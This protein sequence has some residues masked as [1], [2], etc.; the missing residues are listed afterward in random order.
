ME[1]WHGP[2][3]SMDDFDYSVHIAERDWSAFFQECEGCDVL[4]GTLASLDDSGMS[5]NDSGMELE[6][7]QPQPSSNGQLNLQGSSLN[8]SG[9][10]VSENGGEE[11]LSSPKV[12][13][14]EESSA[15]LNCSHGGSV[16]MPMSPC[17]PECQNCIDHQ[18]IL[19]K[20]TESNDTSSS[21]AKGNVCHETDED[22]S[23]MM[24]PKQGDGRSSNEQTGIPLYPQ[25]VFLS[26]E[27]SPTDSLTHKEMISESPEN[28]T[29]CTEL[30]RKEKERWFVTVD[31]GVPRSRARGSTPVKKK[32]K[33]ICRLSCELA[34][35]CNDTGPAIQNKPEL[36][37]AAGQNTDHTSESSLSSH[38]PPTCTPKSCSFFIKLLSE[39]PATKK[40]PKFIGIL[41]SE[42]CKNENMLQKLAKNCI[43]NKKSNAIHHELS[44]TQESID[45]SL[46]NITKTELKE[47]N[48][49][50]YSSM[51]THGKTLAH[52]TC[53][54]KVIPVQKIQQAMKLSHSTGNTELK[55]LDLDSNNEYEKYEHKKTNTAMSFKECEGKHLAKKDV[56]GILSAGCRLVPQRDESTSVLLSEDLRAGCTTTHFNSV[57]NPNGNTLSPVTVNKNRYVD[58]GEAHL[59]SALP[60]V[61]G[62]QHTIRESYSDDVA[63]DIHNLQNRNEVSDEVDYSGSYMTNRVFIID[64]PEKYDENHPKEDRNVHILKMN[65]FTDSTGLPLLD[66]V[67]TK[68]HK[69]QSDLKPSH[70]YQTNC[71]TE[72]E[73]SLSQ[74]PMTLDPEHPPVFAISSFWDEMEKLTISDILQ[75]K[76]VGHT[77]SAQTFPHIQDNVAV[78]TSDADDAGYFTNV[79][80]FKPDC[81]T[82]EVPT[83]SDSEEGGSHSL[84]F[85][86][87]STPEPQDTKNRRSSATLSSRDDVRNKELYLNAGT[88]KESKKR[89]KSCSERPFPHPHH[90]DVCKYGFNQ[91]TPQNVKTAYQMNNV[92]DGNSD[93]LSV[94]EMY[95]YFFL[96]SKPG[97]FSSSIKNTA[98]VPIFSSFQSIRQSLQ[99]PE[100]YD[101]LLPNDSIIQLEDEE[102]HTGTR[103]L[104]RFDS[105]ISDL[106]DTEVL[107][108]SYE[109]FCTDSDW[110]GNLFWRH[111]LSLRRTCF[112]WRNFGRL[113]CDPIFGRIEAICGRQSLCTT[114]RSTIS[115]DVQHC[116][117]DIC[118]LEKHTFS[119]LAEEEQAIGKLQTALS[120]PRRMGCLLLRKQSD[121]CLVCIA[122]A[123]W[124]LRS[125]EP[126][127]AG[128]WRNVLLANVSAVYAIRY[129]R[130]YIQD[131]T[132]IDKL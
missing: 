40:S 107:P 126:Q 97:N 47:T 92:D 21:A 75:L 115:Q 130:K 123:S 25:S 32:K 64:E 46:S 73:S 72:T 42:T 11:N 111:P 132:T 41:P 119:E 22:S 55:L 20:A 101:C 110:R 118:Y 83:F 68:A 53:K 95:D 52:A 54:Q 84:H 105:R 8:T 57:L 37:E 79:D 51:A 87:S 78:D 106:L 14:R 112:T 96:E 35:K 113:W 76:L 89:T 127:N 103:A 120:V 71:S 34:L 2:F 26:S 104:T 94:P 49:S 16:T 80:E 128:T 125:A 66:P 129:L 63:A 69:P 59:D 58:V 62:V 90:S 27:D 98:T 131:D 50:P 12:T 30:P 56:D 19:G 99:F 67:E 61:T 74:E 43:T 38:Q 18:D 121:M 116:S 29:S 3:A 70:R 85:S 91:K 77:Y 6:E 114:I 109:H 9:F 10:Q 28:V 88:E 36:E 102:D 86:T 100:V 65:K 108:D 39:K 17:Q 81:S 33:K 93:S 1:M 13:V 7:L 4:Q 45:T 31:I 44:C 24:D 23:G 15:I 60:Q 5:D 122:F 82:A 48:N 117:A 124:L